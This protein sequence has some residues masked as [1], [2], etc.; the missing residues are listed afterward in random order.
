MSLAQGAVSWSAV[1]DCG[2]SCADPE[3]GGGGLDPPEKS[4][5]YKVF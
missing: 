1:F 2:I 4:Q 3:V 5:K